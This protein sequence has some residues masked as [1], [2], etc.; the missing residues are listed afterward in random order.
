[1]KNVE[2]CLESSRRLSKQEYLERAL[3]MEAYAGFAVTC[4]VDVSGM[5]SRRLLYIGAQ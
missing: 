5:L 4:D 1:M 2:E 3:R